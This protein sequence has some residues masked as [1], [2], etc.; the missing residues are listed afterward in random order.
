[1]KFIIRVAGAAIIALMASTVAGLPA[2]T[3]AENQAPA[4]I[5]AEKAAQTITPSGCNPPAWDRC[6]AE[7]KQYLLDHACDFRLCLMAGNCT[8]C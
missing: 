8:P 1:M 7:E 6:S 4:A 3:G 2:T 5:V